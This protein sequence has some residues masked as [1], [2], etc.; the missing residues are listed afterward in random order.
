MILFS[1]NYLDL[2]NAGDGR[3][4]RRCSTTV[5]TTVGTIR[6]GWNIIA[7]RDGEKDRNG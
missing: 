2:Q 6:F 7:V 4:G 5:A 1:F 3:T